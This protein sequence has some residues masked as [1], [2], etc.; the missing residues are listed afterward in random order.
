MII[1]MIA[2]VLAEAQQ[3]YNVGDVLYGKDGRKEGVIFWVDPEGAGGWAVALRNACDTAVVWGPDGVDIPG[4]DNIDV[5]E[6]LSDFDGYGNTGKLRAYLGIGTTYAAQIVDYDNGWYLPSCGQMDRLLALGT[7]IDPILVLHG[8]E[9]LITKIDLTDTDAYWTSNTNDNMHAFTGDFGFYGLFPDTR[10]YYAG[11]VRAVRNFKIEDTGSGYAYLWNTGATTSNLTVSPQAGKNDYS[12]QV[13]AERGNCMGSAQKTVM[14]AAPG[15]S[16]FTDT[17]CRGQ[18]YRLNGFNTGQAGIYD[19]TFLLAGGCS[20]EARLN[21]AVADTFYVLMTDFF[22]KGTPYNKYN[23]T[24]YYPGVYV[25]RWQ[26]RQGCDSTIVL[27]LFE[28]QPVSTTYHGSV[29]SGESFASY[30]F[31]VPSVV[32]DTFCWRNSQ[33]PEGCDSLI[34]LELSVIPPLRLDIF[35]TVCSGQPYVGFEHFDLPAVTRD[36]I[37]QYVTQSV[38]GCDSVVYLHLYVLE[39]PRKYITAFICEGDIYTDYGF[40]LS[41]A[42]EY[43][44]YIPSS[45]GCDTLLHLSL[46]VYPAQGTDLYASVC[47]G[48]VYTGHPLCQVPPIT[49]DTLCV[50]RLLTDHGCDSLVNIH[51]TWQPL[52]SK[53]VDVSLRQGEFYTG[54]GLHIGNPGNYVIRWPALVGC[55]T[56]V[57]VRVTLQAEFEK[58]IEASICQGERY[59]DHGFNEAEPGE[60]TRKIMGIGG[61]TL[62]YLALNVHPTY[63]LSLQDVFCE[64]ERYMEHGFDSDKEGVFRIMMRSIYGCDSLVELDLRMNPV[65]NTVIDTVI[66]EGEIFVWEDLSSRQEGEYIFRY[67][68]SQGCDSLTTFRLRIA[69]SLQVPNTFSPNGDGINDIFMP[70]YRVEVFD[71]NGMPIFQGNDGWDGCRQG[72]QV[73]PD[74]YFYKLYYI[75]AGKEKVKKGFITLAR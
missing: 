56:V 66:E 36:T 14:V 59:T 6:G 63:E 11:K 13:I 2:C 34:Y 42:G 28:N 24:A 29:C 55:D 26:T 33:T 46:A 73:T 19:T 3:T 12:V 48:E 58:R 41:V 70:G 10:D 17:I 68:S 54:Y 40:H 52:E 21:L 65:W 51:L 44:T 30:G 23:F 35:D 62:V 61:D 7:L 20:I 1:G 75:Q 37:C 38:H 57:S 8:G 72:R 16:E 9:T 64:G 47:D 50:V 60:Y 4:L 27:N 25:Q 31:Y 69:S 22:C 18:E 67:E 5:L 53:T 71:R 43:D 45:A 39:Y 49:H 74:V 15:V 32:R